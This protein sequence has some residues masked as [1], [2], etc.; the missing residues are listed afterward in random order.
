MLRRRGQGGCCGA[1]VHGGGDGRGAH[2]ATSV[3]TNR[4]PI[5]LLSSA[6]P[7]RLRCWRK[8]SIAAGEGWTVNHLGPCVSVKRS[9]NKSGTYEKEATSRREHR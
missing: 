7:M 9:A 6:L 2:I 1:K 4:L 3:G 8:G 5:L